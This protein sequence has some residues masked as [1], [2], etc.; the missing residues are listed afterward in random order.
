MT[1]WAGYGAIVLAHALSVASPGPDFFIVVRTSIASGKKAGIAC[2]SGIGSG[3]LCMSMFAVH[4][5][6]FSADSS[7]FLRFVSF[8]GAVVLC[9]FGVMWL[10]SGLQSMRDPHEKL[11]LVDNELAQDSDMQFFK[12]Y[13]M[14]VSVN[15]SNAKAWLFF[16]ALVVPFI[17]AGAGQGSRVALS[18]YLAV[19]TFLWFALVVRCIELPRFRSWLEKNSA[20]IDVI[21]GGA[22]LIL[23]VLLLHFGLVVGIID[24]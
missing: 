8:A 13:M 10:R 11:D 1:E 15:L 23:G 5:G 16:I 24:P 19:A 4:I 21:S 2:A 18:V 14:G 6:F 7:L 22:M 17:P 12:A 3:I 20:G 9:W